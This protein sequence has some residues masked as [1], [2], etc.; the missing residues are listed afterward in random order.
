MAFSVSPSPGGAVPAAPAP[1]VP[2]GAGAAPVVP[3]ATTL[4]EAVEL[5]IARTRHTKTGS[6]HTEQ[7]YRTDLRHLGAFLTGRRRSYHDVVR[8][9]AALYL[10]RLATRYA[11]RTVRRRI[12]TCR[13][14]YR[15]LRG[16][17]L[18]AANPFDALDLPSF[19]RRSETH[20]V[21]TDEE[22]ERVL[23]LLRSDVDEANRAFVEAEAGRPKQ[24]AFGRLFAA[25]RRRAA[26]TLMGLGG[27]RCAEVLHLSAE[28]IIQRPDGFY[29]RFAGKGEKVR[30]VPL[31]GFA[32]PA[33]FD[34]LSVRRHVPAA[35]DRVL[36]TLTGRPVRRNQMQRD[37]RAL[38]DR[39]E[40]GVAEREPQEAAPEHEAQQEGEEAFR[41]VSHAQEK[42]RSHVCGP[43]P[44]GRR[45]CAV[46]VR[47]AEIDDFRATRG[48]EAE[49]RGGQGD[50]A[51]HVAQVEG[52]RAAVGVMHAD[53]RRDGVRGPD[54]ER[55]VADRHAAA[56]RAQR[57][58]VV[59]DAAD[60]GLRGRG[61]AEHVE[62]VGEQLPDREADARGLVVLHD[63]LVVVAR[64]RPQR[65]AVGHEH[66]LAEV[67]AE[68]VA[69]DGEGALEALA[70]G[71]L[72]EG[73]LEGF[74]GAVALLE[75]LRDGLGGLGLRLTGDEDGGGE[76]DQTQRARE[77]RTSHG[78]GGRGG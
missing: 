13:S 1:D 30:T 32:Y 39:A 67:E 44:N 29:L 17:E 37:C 72:H 58:H 76:G 10:S 36:V 69:A 42:A 77:E 52:Q 34:W 27:L 22:H 21:L 38:G 12:S 57:Q 56:P 47:S 49:R 23:A 62:V 78:R 26:L 31:V 63:H 64:V 68:R 60:G 51:A 28:S 71:G 35:T 19:D 40:V 18:V 8:R 3:A 16:I 24:V 43:A 53:A 14:F 55:R 59:G 70:T 9:D 73:G 25:T 33:V 75:A 4:A 41:S 7:A 2:P 46:R 5:F 65:A 45:E 11:P 20:K 54:V 15:F 6:A 66:L 50:V 61:H 74:E 48:V